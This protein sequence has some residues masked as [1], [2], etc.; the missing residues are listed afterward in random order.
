MLLIDCGLM[1]TQ[2]HALVNVPLDA[3]KKEHVVALQWTPGEQ[4][5]QL[6]TATSL[7]QVYL[8]SQGCSQTGQEHPATVDEW[9]GAQAIQ[10]DLPD[11]HR[12]TA[13]ESQLPRPLRAARGM[14]P[15]V[16]DMPSYLI[17]QGLASCCVGT[18][19]LGSTALTDP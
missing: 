1:M 11:V 14:V 7:S 4:L 13:L 19:S 6:M 2:E 17:R 5:R 9:S 12:A 3:T 16:S 8:W 10:F 15:V 18:C